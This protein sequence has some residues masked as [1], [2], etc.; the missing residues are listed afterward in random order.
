MR[1]GKRWRSEVDAELAGPMARGA[2]GQDYF[3]HELALGLV[4]NVL[5]PVMIA[6]WFERHGALFAEVHPV[7]L[8]SDG[9]GYIIDARQEKMFDIALND[10]KV[11][12]VELGK[13]ETHRFHH[14][15]HPDNIEGILS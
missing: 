9:A 3:V 12:V 13:H 14:L 5:V 7:R 10:L 1:Q 6:R 8:T 4:H 2:D 15:P 11:S